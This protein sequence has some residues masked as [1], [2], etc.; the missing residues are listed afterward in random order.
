MWSKQSPTSDGVS[1]DD[2][3]I[4]S[5]VSQLQ[6]QVSALQAGSGS[7]T[8]TP[9]DVTNVDAYFDAVSTQG[10]LLPLISYDCSIFPNYS[11]GG[12]ITVEFTPDF[13]TSPA[14]IDTV[15]LWLGFNSDSSIGWSSLDSGATPVTIT[16]GTK[17]TLSKNF[18]PQAS[19]N[20]LGIVPKFI[21][22]SGNT[23]TNYKVKL[24]NVIVKIN[25]VEVP[26]NTLMNSGCHSAYTVSVNSAVLTKT[27]S[28]S[29]VPLLSRWAARRVCTYGD[30]ITATSHSDGSLRYPNYLKQILNFK[31]LE[32]R[33]ASGMSISNLTTTNA[34][35]NQVQRHQDFDLV[36]I[37][38][39][40]NDYS[41]NVPLG[42]IGSKNDVTTSFDKGT[43]HGAY[44]YCLDTVIKSNQ[45]ATIVLLLPITKKVES[46]NS[47]GLVV[48][49]YRNAI[50]N[51]GKMYNLPVCDTRVCINQNNVDKFL[52]DG[53]HIEDLGHR[54]IADFLSSFLT[55]C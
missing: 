49:D 32:D 7:V 5:N 45:F 16:S 25:G 51:I 41:F 14:L 53:L 8:I 43:F 46:A 13:S 9:P 29:P 39:G 42:T 10:F 21:M 52:Y 17:I 48:D 15:A 12:T 26:K 35:V 22:T 18:T 19:K 6:T 38:L 54:K 44:R 28:Y 4:K 24:S 36:T 20:Y 3:I 50:I 33:S 37:A 27:A 55:T 34:L 1:Y 11:A 31:Y 47:V 40:I 30:S 2:T 23:N